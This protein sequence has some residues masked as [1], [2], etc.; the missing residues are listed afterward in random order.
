MKNVMYMAVTNDELALPIV[1]ADNIDEL[2]ALTGYGENYL[3][4]LISRPDRGCRVHGESAK[5]IKVK[6]EDGDGTEG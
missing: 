4:H 5:I 1:V 3:F 2:S 6:L